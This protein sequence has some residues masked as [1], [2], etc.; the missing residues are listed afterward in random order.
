MFADGN[1]IMWSL[2]QM[3]A[4]SRCCIAFERKKEIEN[5]RE[6]KRVCSQYKITTHI[7]D[8]I[9]R[10]RSGWSPGS[11]LQVERL[12]DRTNEWVWANTWLERQERAALNLRIPLHPLLFST[13]Y[14]S[15]FSS[16]AFPFPATQMTLGSAKYVQAVVR[17]N[18]S[19][20]MNKTIFRSAFIKKREIDGSLWNS[21]FALFI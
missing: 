16:R 9:Q 13:S 14:S 8:F 12:C 21:V 1:E 4:E 5:E 7:Q 3:S 17:Q 6:K 11:A 20:M 19:Y 15:L 2:W 10:I 18:W